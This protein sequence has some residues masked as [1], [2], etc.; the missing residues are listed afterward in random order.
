MVTAPALGAPCE[1][2]KSR[3]RRLQIRQ[4]RSAPSRRLG[5]AVRPRTVQPQ[6]PSSWRVSMAQL[7]QVSNNHRQIKKE[8][9]PLKIH[10]KRRRGRHERVPGN[11]CDRDEFFLLGGGG[12]GG[13]HHSGG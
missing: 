2:L 9:P 4:R 12:G 3:S 11:R 1:N 5:H 7:K 13:H 8:R 6:T 10:R